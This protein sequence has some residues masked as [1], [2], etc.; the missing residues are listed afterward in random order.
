MLPAS[1]VEVHDALPGPLAQRFWLVELFWMLDPVVT[2]QEVQFVHQWVLTS[3]LV[4]RRKDPATSSLS[5]PSLPF[6]YVFPQNRVP[7]G[8]GLKK[9]SSWNHI[10]WQT[11]WIHFTWS[12]SHCPSR[13]LV[14]SLAHR[15]WTSWPQ[16]FLC[17]M[18]W[19]CSRWR[20]TGSSDLPQLCTTSV[21]VRRN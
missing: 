16:S 13:L 19:I 17:L 7:S 1:G 5:G 2:L 8:S 11:P 12:V 20:E 3:G 14:L 18:W 9:I 15:K 4:I 21:G 6:V 10:T